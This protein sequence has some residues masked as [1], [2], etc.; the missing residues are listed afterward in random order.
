MPHNLELKARHGDLASAA[1]AAARLGTVGPSVLLQTDTYFRVPHG[2]LK[3]REIEGGA[4]ELI[5]YDRPDRDEAR[6][7]AYEVMHVPDPAM[8]QS[9]LATALGVRGQVRKR[10]TLYLWHNVRIHL[11]EVT[12]LGTFV[13]FEAVLSAGEDEARARARL[14]ELGRALGVRPEDGL[15]GSYADLLGLT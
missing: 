8:L 12:G 11:D 10:R 7:S 15:A 3:L 4:A 9:I 5:G 1:A 6:T 14:E 13:E 2:R